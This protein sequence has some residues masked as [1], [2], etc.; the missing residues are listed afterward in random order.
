MGGLLTRC[1]RWRRWAGWRQRSRR[2]QGAAAQGG[3][4]RRASHGDVVDAARCSCPVLEALGRD[5]QCCS[6]TTSGMRR[7][8]PKFAGAAM[9]NEL[10]RHCLAR[11][12]MVDQAV[13]RVGEADRRPRQEPTD[14]RQRLEPVA[15]LR[16]AHFECPSRWNPKDTTSACGIRVTG[17]AA[18][19]EEFCGKLSGPVICLHPGGNCA[20]GA[21]P[22]A[23][24]KANRRT[25][26]HLS[27]RQRTIARP[28][29]T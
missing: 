11:A 15:T 4:P 16:S 6:T 23:A 17:S 3:F 25:E 7:D 14:H 19:D 24:A 2:G 5:A 13:D 26:K 8:S 21:E 12:M 18:P 1:L 10:Q 20:A 27:S 9:P 22:L 29:T 28:H